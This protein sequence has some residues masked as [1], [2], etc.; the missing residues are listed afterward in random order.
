MQTFTEKTNSMEQNISI[1]TIP[2]SEYSSLK[3]KV[4]S[5]SR[6]VGSKT[7][8]IQNLKDNQSIIRETIVEG[9]YGRKV[10][11][12]VVGIDTIKEELRKELENTLEKENKNLLSEVKELKRNNTYLGS[13]LEDKDAACELKID[14]LNRENKRTLHIMR[15]DYTENLEKKNEKI[16]KLQQE[17]QKIKDSKT[18][19]EVE[20]AR[21]KEILDLKTRISLLEEEL[22]R[23]EAMNF[24]KRLV[25]RKV[26]SAAEKEVA[27]EKA[28]LK[29]VT[30]QVGVT[31]V[32]EDGRI[33]RSRKIATDWWQAVSPW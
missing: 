20:E 28:R 30:S 15:E 9:N 7:E 11:K 24:F 22:A 31:Y 12:E 29:K 1:V 2:L 5:L 23:Y 25:T 13:L 19:K 26:A 8:L 14:K 6:E 4:E 3:D 32:K 16:E 21:N 10:T 27:K 33:E 17:I 18:D